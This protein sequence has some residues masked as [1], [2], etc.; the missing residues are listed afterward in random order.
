MNPLLWFAEQPPRGVFVVVRLFGHRS[1]A[2]K[3]APRGPRRFKLAL[4]KARRTSRNHPASFTT[5][6]NWRILRKAKNSSV[7][8]VVRG[9]SVDRQGSRGSGRQGL[10]S[11]PGIG[12]AAGER[13]L[14]RA[15]NQRSRIR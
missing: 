8:P 15:R 13:N 14:Q 10:G 4:N 2:G 5:Q 9:G 12:R 7:F 1:T 3:T 11:P 6:G